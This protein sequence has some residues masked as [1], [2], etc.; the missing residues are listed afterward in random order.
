MPTLDELSR[1]ADA[2][3]HAASQNSAEWR[4]LARRP[5]VPPG[6]AQDRPI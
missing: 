1:I 6:A 2:P 4:T 5:G 3:L